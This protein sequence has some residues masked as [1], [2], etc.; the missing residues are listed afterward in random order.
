ME[1]R[2]AIFI[3]EADTQVYSLEWFRHRRLLKAEN[4]QPGGSSQCQGR[5]GQDLVLKVPCG[6]LVKDSQTGEVLHDLTEDKQRVVLCLGGR[7]GRGNESFKSPTHQ[8]PN[9][10]TEGKEGTIANVE[11]ELKLIADIGLVGF[12]NAG[13]STLI[14]ALAKVRVKIA[15]YP[16]TTLQPNLGYIE[17]EDYTRTL[18][19][20]IPGIIEGATLACG[21]CFLHHAHW[22]QHHILIG[23]ALRLLHARGTVFL[24]SLF[25]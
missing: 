16:F 13:K 12:P 10:C 17:N 15:P 7:G 24:L 14:S 6:T 11:L 1:E 2:A 18:I 8:A 4:G 23:S 25:S 20:D 21:V 22:V 5:N 9:I 19:A 3:I